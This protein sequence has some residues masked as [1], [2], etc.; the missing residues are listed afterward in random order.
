MKYNVIRSV[1][2]QGDVALIRVDVLPQ[3]VEEVVSQDC[4]RVVLAYGEVTGHAHAIYGEEMAHVHVWAAGMV[5]YLEVLATAKANFSQS[6]I[7]V[8]ADGVPIE[9]EAGVHSGVVLKHEEHTYQLIPPGIYKL[10]VQTEYTPAE[11]RRTVD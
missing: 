5:K 9:M 8:G 6:I 10:P 2:R 4:A 1:I 11:L 7:V 3:G